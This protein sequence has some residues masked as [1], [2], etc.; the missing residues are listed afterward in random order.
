MRAFTVVLS[1]SFWNRVSI[2]SSKEIENQHLLFNFPSPFT[3]LKFDK[4]YFHSF[5]HIISKL[6]HE[7]N[8]IGWPNFHS[9]F[10]C[11]RHLHLTPIMRPKLSVGSTAKRVPG[12]CMQVCYSWHA[13]H[14]ISAI[15]IITSNCLH[16]H[17]SPSYTGEQC[18]CI[19]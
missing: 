16:Y 10:L 14:R 7:M 18:N 11:P 9:R 6:S 2:K 8:G 1:M 13:A 4:I 5:S 12:R 19:N 17:H 15:H 3:P